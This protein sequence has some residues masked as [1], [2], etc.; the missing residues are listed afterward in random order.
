L[1]ELTAEDL[2]LLEVLD[3]H[4]R[5]NKLDFFEPYPKQLAF[6]A[7]GAIKKERM[8][9]AGNQLGK[10]FVGAYETAVH[11]T[12]LY[13]KDWPGRKW[14][15]PVKGWAAGESTE[16]VRDVSQQLLCGPHSDED[17]YGTG[18]IPGR[19]L[20]GRPTLRP[21]AV[22]QAYDTIKV[23]HHTNGVADGISR[24]SFKSYEQKRTKFQGSTLDFVWWDEE[25]DMEIYTEGN[26]RWSATDGMS[27]MTF[28]P[29]KGMSTVVK[30]F[31]YESDEYRGALT[32]GIADAKH[33][34][35]EAQKQL[36][37]K[38][39]QHEWKARMDGIPMLGEGR[40]FLTREEDML[41]P[42]LYLTSH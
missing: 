41:C 40:I 13:P 29:L 14:N 27:W 2:E 12:G 19:C 22:S 17:G 3:K 6:I 18:F 4:R 25:P 31:L 26:A 21:G 36:L 28:T 42:S 10:S 23:R 15:R 35:A 32:M 7:L 9:F 38:Y 34:T 39:P 30:R 24:L 20:V 11:L 33:M 1:S 8:L 5:Y 37:S 16:V